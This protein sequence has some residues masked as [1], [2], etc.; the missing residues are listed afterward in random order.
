M[1]K[2]KIIEV[3]SGINYG[4]VEMLL[5]NYFNMMNL[6]KFDISIITHDIPNNENK[7]EFN[8]LGIQIYP[9]TP[10][11]KNIFKNILEILKII[12][13]IKPD[14]IHC[15]MTLS[16]YMPLILAKI[17]NVKVRIAHSHEANNKGKLDKLYQLLINKT[18][19]DFLSCSPQ[20]SIYSYGKN[21]KVMLFP[22]AINMEKF[23][24][25]RKKRK[26]I[27]SEY[28]IPEDYVVIGNVGRFVE[29]KNQKRLLN[30]FAIYLKKHTKSFLM[31]IGDGPLKEELKKYAEQIGIKENIIFVNNVNNIY[32]FYNCFDYFIQTSISE[33]FGLTIIEAQ[34]NGLTCVISFSIPKI[35]VINNNV[36]MID[37]NESDEDWVRMIDSMDKK[38]TED[39]LVINSDFNLKKSYLK[40]EKIYEERGK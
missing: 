9:V 3:V 10:K 30:I 32:D 23:L 26:Q 27:R 19:T 4:G 15:H 33:G 21:K 1:K 29:V 34:T 20:S 11:R 18:A 5:Y 22:N 7:K 12:K 39:L 36:K 17:C 2:I 35:V 28:D 37:L 38:R 8:D 14:I 25:N 40:L 13:R 6:N 31:L 24:F 16:N